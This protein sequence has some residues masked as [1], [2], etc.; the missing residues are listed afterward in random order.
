ME[1]AKPSSSAPPY[2][3]GAGAGGKFR[4][5]PVSRKRPSTPYDRPSLT[6]NNKPDQPQDGGGGGWLSKLVVNPARRLIFGGATRILPSFFSKSESSSADEYEDDS[7]SD[8]DNEDI[9]ATVN[10]YGDATHTF[11]VGVPSSSGAAGPSKET[12]K[13]KGIADHNI[14]QQEKLKNSI[15]DFGVDKI[16]NMLKGKQ[17]SRDESKRLMEILNSRLVDVSNAEG[18]QKP[19]SM[20]PQGQAKP[21]ASN[22]E[23]P[24]ALTWGKQY[25]VEKTV[26]ETPMPRLQSNMQEEVGASPIDIARAYMGSRTSEVGF[27]AYNNIS[28]D[29]REHQEQQIDLFPSK[30]HFLTPSSKS[31]T[32]WPGAMVQDQR[33]YLTPQN[34]RGRYGL[35][36]FPRTPYS[37]TIYSRTK[38]KLNQLQGDNRSSNLS[39][40]SFQQSQTPNRWQ[41]KT[42]S[43]V[44]DG[45][46]GSVGPIRRVRNKF[47][48][49]PQSEGPRTLSSAQL[50]SSSNAS[51]SFVPVFQKNLITAGGTSNP[52][53]TDKNE[54]TNKA[55]TSP[56]GPSNETVRKIL[57]QL[58]RHKPTPK[59][60]AAELKLATEWKRS[61]SQDNT[62]LMPKGSTLFG[63]GPTLQKGSVSS[64]VGSFAKATDNDP[65][66]T[67]IAATKTFSSVADAG[68]GAGP[69]FGF[70]NTGVAN[71]K[72]TVTEK[73]KE[74]SQP[75]SFSNQVNGQDLA[76]KRPSQPILK[77]ISFKKP[78]PQQVISSDNGRGFTFPFSAT[79]SSASEPPTPSIMPSFTSPA[80][81]QSNELTAI[82]TYSFG[83]K[84]SGERVVFSFPST[85]NAPIADGESDLKF[86]FGSDKKRVSFGSVKSDAIVIN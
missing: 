68:A 31:S 63:T 6:T 82:P 59:E 55:E 14:I 41:M 79:A 35:H 19:A 46:Y 73:E 30:P 50:P 64:D 38:P 81:P 2:S 42:S 26:L 18:E 67:S 33:G 3:G 47:A 44:M 60:K 54:Q 21:D 12:D 70:R 77:P 86:T 16:E 29:G 48:S 56:T 39:L 23:T 5:P 25:D 36:N 7:S 58:D 52:Q 45:G 24:S 53:T 83:T 78:D 32:C 80:V 72:P 4:K 28:T 9:V 10:A 49:E 62:N 22:R 65:M 51:R 15:D 61:S 8:Q 34:Q 1:S 75:W 43:E 74:K 85:S 37:R 71:E 40:N 76:R 27:N 20:I 11:E 13:L 84:K 17:F 69:S 57:E 66:K